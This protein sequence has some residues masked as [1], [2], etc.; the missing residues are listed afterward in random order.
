MPHVPLPHLYHKYS[1][2]GSKY[3]DVTNELFLIRELGTESKIWG[4]G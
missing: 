4:F 1:T 2:V 3:F